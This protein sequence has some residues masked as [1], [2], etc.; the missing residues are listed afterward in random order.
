[1]GLKSQGLVMPE[2]S[3]QWPESLRWGRPGPALVITPVACTQAERE[4]RISRGVRARVVSTLKG[5]GGQMPSQWVSDM[6]V[7]WEVPLPLSTAGA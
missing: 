4:A 1:M 6:G 7:G 5:G 3:F 2:W